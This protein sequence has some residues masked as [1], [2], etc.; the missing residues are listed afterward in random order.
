MGI[1]SA[2]FLGQNY[3]LAEAATRLVL[4]D[5]PGY[6][7]GLELHAWANVR[8]HI[9]EGSDSQGDPQFLKRGGGR[10]PQAAPD[11]SQAGKRGVRVSRCDRKPAR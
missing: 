1:A 2:H 9:D 8:L 7:P 5:T 4:A 6:T 3:A 10:G 11:G